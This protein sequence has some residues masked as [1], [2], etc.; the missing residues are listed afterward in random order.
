MVRQHPELVQSVLVVDL[1]VQTHPV[2]K[3][4]GVSVMYGSAGSRETLLHAGVQHAKLVISTIPDELLRGTSNRA[5]VSAV[6]AVAP[7]ATIFACGS[8]A[9]QIDELYAAGA[10]YVYMPSA[11][12]AN[13]VFAAS[14]AALAGQLE[15]YRATREAACGPLQTRLDVERMS[16]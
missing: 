6:R 2:I 9:M 3:Q 16:T 10:T 13:G 7:Q 15:D 4:L 5:I 14:L 11:E 8:R 12:T 1:N